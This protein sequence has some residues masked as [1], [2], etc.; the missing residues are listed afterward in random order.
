M[1]WN[2]LKHREK[3]SIESFIR[4]QNIMIIEELNG[5]SRIRQRKSGSPLS[6]YA[7]ISKTKFIRLLQG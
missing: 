7:V 4:I 3:L 2:F 1:K 5:T 6:S